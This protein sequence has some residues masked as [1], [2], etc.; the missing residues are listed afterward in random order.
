MLYI[1][2][3][4]NDL[5]EEQILKIKSYADILIE[6]NKVIN[7]VSRKDIENL[8]L[9]HILH[10]LS[11]LKFLTLKPN[12]SVLDV[13]TGGGLPGIPLSILCPQCNFVL[14]DS[15][16]KKIKVVSDIIKKINLTNVIAIHQNI[17]FYKEKHDYIIQ[18]AVMSFKEFIH[19]T[20][21]NSKDNTI[22]IAFKGGNI[23]DEIKGFENKVKVFYI[24]NIIKENY[25][26]DKK[27]V[28][29]NS[30]IL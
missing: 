7:L 20:R 18:R 11:L 26:R 27:I 15:I 13:G 3:Y 14:I 5:T 30:D 19:L 21:K 28:I 9:H 10:S 6:W 8:Y 4:F 17:K 16:E 23:N 29:L 24:D 1:L 2:K 12:S 22:F 25:F